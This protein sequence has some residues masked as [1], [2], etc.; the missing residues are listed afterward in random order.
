MR[1][2]T[3][4]SLICL[5]TACTAG[6]SSD[7]TQVVS[8]WRGGNANDLLRVWGKPYM[9][10]VTGGK[11]TYTYQRSG[12]FDPGSL[13]YS[14]SVGVVPRSKGAAIVTQNP[15]VNSPLNRNTTVYC[16]TVFT[17]APNGKIIAVSTYG[18]R[19]YSNM[20]DLGNPKGR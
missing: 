11:T 14:P 16:T 10:V 7:Y 12:P 18:N 3:L 17:A 5:L 15:T 2:L 13:T 6:G 1:N 4:V 8:G 20:S 19:C 9:T